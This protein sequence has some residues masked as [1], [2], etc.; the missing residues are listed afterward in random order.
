[1]RASARMRS[2][3]IC[4]L[5]AASTALAAVAPPMIGPEEYF[6]QASASIVVSSSQL[7]AVLYY[8]I[9]QAPTV[10]DASIEY[11]GPVPLSLTGDVVVAAQANVNST[12]SSLVVRRYFVQSEFCS[13]RFAV[14]CSICSC[15]KPLM[16]AN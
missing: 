15:A 6:L 7:D 12:S 10:P 8:G 2:L 14:S 9:A 1:M 16:H 5:C 4:I 3:A 13:L 11:Q